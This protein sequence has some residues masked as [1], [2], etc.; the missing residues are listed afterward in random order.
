VNFLCGAT[1]L[2]LQ[3][4]TEAVPY[5]RS[6]VTTN[7]RLLPTP[8]AIGQALLQTGKAEEA[9]RHLKAGLAT[10]EDGDTHFRSLR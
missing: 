10:D 1:L 3:R 7:P 6:A 5:L 8:A 9:I 4:P 2:N